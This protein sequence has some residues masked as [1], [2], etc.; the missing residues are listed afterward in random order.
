MSILMRLLT[1]GKSLVGLKDDVHRY[2][3]TN[4]RLLPCFGGGKNPFQSAATAIDAQRSQ[5]SSSA[6]GT[7]A[8][9][10]GSKAPAPKRTF[11]SSLTKHHTNGSMGQPERAVQCELSLDRVQVVRN[12]LS[13]GDLEV[14]PLRSTAQTKRKATDA[15]PT[16]KVEEPTR[17]GQVTNRLFGLIRT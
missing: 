17:S 5:S 8:T 14:V 3:T 7:T 1:S 10:S 6:G 15:A 13:D 4:H 2:R 9:N 12:D 11:F 16:A